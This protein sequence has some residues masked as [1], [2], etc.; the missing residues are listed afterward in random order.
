[1]KRILGILTLLLSIGLSAQNVSDII[2]SEVYVEGDGSLVDGYGRKGAWI[3]IYNTSMGSVNLCGCYL[4]DDPT[5]PKKSP[6]PKNDKKLLL[7]P[8]QSVI[9]YASGDNTDGSFYVGFVPE[10]GGK[11]YFISNDGKT[12]IDSIDIPSDLPEG[13]SVGKLPIDNKG[14][15]FST[16]AEPLKP[17]P[18]APNDRH[19]TE[20]GTER[21]AHEDPHGFIL[22]AVAVTVVF[23][24]LAI[25]WLLF[26]L[27]FERPA[28]ISAQKKADGEAEGKG[29]LW[30]KGN[31]DGKSRGKDGAKGGKDSATG[32]KDGARKLRIEDADEETAIAIALALSMEDGQEDIAAI[33]AAM[34]LYLS[35]SCHDNE[36]Y[37]I[38]FNKEATMWNNR[39]FGFRKVPR[40]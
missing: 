10:K 33:A 12:I 25:L 7:G 18:G 15:C 14:I 4:S 40:K 27:L 16:A 34:D 31:R 17:T 30:R 20:S 29:I 9:F 37:V 39:S 13:M 23:C 5:A 1:M 22:A 6:I 38:T 8:R 32:G 24:S 2:I 21:M 11:V 3:E 28:K 35:E 19:M 26:Y 36:S